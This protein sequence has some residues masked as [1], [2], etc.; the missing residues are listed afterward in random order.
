MIFFLKCILFMWVSYNEF[1]VYDI[2]I[3]MRFFFA[4]LNNKI[5]RQRFQKD[6]NHFAGMISSYRKPNIQIIIYSQF[7]QMYLFQL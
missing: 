6:L 1:K 7:C 3:R 4:K 5:D 2:Y